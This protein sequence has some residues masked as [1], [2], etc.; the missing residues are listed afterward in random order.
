LWEIGVPLRQ[1][2]IAAAANEILAAA[3]SPDQQPPVVGEHWPTRWLKRYLEFTVRK[4]KSIEIERQH[5]MNVE[6]IWDFFIKFQTTV[7]KYKI[8]K[9]DIWNMDETGLRIGVGWGQWVIV[10]AGQEQGRFQNLISSTGDTE[11]VSVVEY[12]SASGEIIAPLIIIKGVV[13]QARWFADIQDGDIAIGVS[14]LGYSNDI[15]SFQWLQHWNRLSKRR[16]QG[17]YRLLIMD[18]YESHLT[19]QFVWY[20]EM[21]KIILLCLPPH[22]TH[23]LQ[24][25]NVVIFQQW[26][27]WHTE[28]I[29]HAVRHG[30]GEFDRQTFL[31][32]IESIRKKT[33]SEGNVKSAFRK[34]GVDLYHLDRHWYFVKSLL[35][36]LF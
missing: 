9:G 24:P 27:H 32:N 35:M 1:K 21:E 26:K 33:F 4:E 30:T 34:C 25:L 22:S 19:I 36:R 14:E 29:D 16:Q 3:C 20:C 23:F 12:I 28:A 7:D 2:I 31:A 6:Q 18:G 13:I 5:A 11:H 8:E 10:P 17:T 15:L